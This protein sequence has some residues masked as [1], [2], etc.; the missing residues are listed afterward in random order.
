MRFMVMVRADRIEI[1]QVYAPDDFDPA[2]TPELRAKEA[3]LRAEG[4]QRNRNKA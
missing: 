4:E 1:R 2:L 3:R